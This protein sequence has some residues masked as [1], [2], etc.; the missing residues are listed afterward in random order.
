MS[1]LPQ[2]GRKKP[3]ILS[4]KLALL[5]SQ[6]GGLLQIKIIVFRLPRILLQFR[7]SQESGMQCFFPEFFG[8]Y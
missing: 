7:A 3:K 5:G 6:T 1:A 4:F 2:S 8:Q